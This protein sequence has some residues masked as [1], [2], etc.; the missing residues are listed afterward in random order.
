[1]ANYIQ[2]YSRSPFSAQFMYFD[3]P[4]YKADAIFIQHGI[5]PRWYEEIDIAGMPFHLI[6]C[7]VWRKDIHQFFAVMDELNTNMLLTGFDH[8]DEQCNEFFDYLENELG[9]MHELTMTNIS[10]SEY[11]HLKTRVENLQLYLKYVEDHAPELM[12]DM[13]EWFDGMPG[14]G[15]VSE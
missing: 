7:R 9:N 13:E 10:V 2:L 12:S 14:Y 6:R 3:L 4:E 1:M 11:E 5:K 15:E 8:Y